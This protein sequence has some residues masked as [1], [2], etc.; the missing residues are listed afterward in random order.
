MRRGISILSFSKK[1]L[2]LFGED[3][4]IHGLRQIAI[5]L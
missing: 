5:K 4:C 2:E 3:T 1:A